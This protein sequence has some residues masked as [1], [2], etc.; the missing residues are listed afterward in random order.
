MGMPINLRGLRDLEDS[1]IFRS[2]DCEFLRDSFK[3]VSKFPGMIEMQA[4]QLARLGIEIYPSFAVK[5]KKLYH[6]YHN[7]V[8]TGVKD[9]T[10]RIGQKI[11]EIAE[12]NSEIN[13][14]EAWKYVTDLCRAR[15]TCYT[16][17]EVKKAYHTLEKFN[18]QRGILKIIPRF[19]DREHD[20]LIVFDYFHVMICELEIKLH[21]TYPI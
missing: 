5:M 10:L 4:A 12:Q 16:P 20:V 19:M 1:S 2:N 8:E 15:I 17:E 7:D 9:N 14:G 3:G 21:D 13:D 6:L 11:R 18:M